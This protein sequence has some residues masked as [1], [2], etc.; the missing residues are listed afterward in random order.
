MKIL[1][2]FYIFK[3]FIMFIFIFF[4][5]NSRLIPLSNVHRHLLPFT[6]HAFYIVWLQFLQI[7]LLILKMVF[8]KHQTILLKVLFLNLHM[9]KLSKAFL[10]NIR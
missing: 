2:L 7:S 9:Q 8:P 3:L 10:N 6:Q 5:L 1:F 4:F